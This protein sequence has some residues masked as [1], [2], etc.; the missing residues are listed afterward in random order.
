MALG[1]LLDSDINSQAAKN[2]GFRPPYAG[3]VG[4][5]AQS[6]RRFPHF[7]GITDPTE[8]LGLANYHSLQILVQ[9]RASYG[10]DLTLAYTLSKGISDAPLNANEG[11]A[12]V[13][14]VFNQRLDKTINSSDAPH[15]IAIGYSY[16]LPVGAGKAVSITHPVLNKVAGG[17]Q[18]TGMWRYYS[19]R[20]I[21]IGGAES[22][23]IFSGNRPQY[24]YPFVPIMTDIGPG[25]FDP[26]TDSY[27]NRAAF[28]TGQR[29]KFGDVP[30]RLPSTR[31]FAFYSENIGLL[32][33]IQIKE[34]VGVELRGEAYNFTNRTRFGGPN[35]TLTS[36]S[37]GRVTSSSSARQM[38]L[39]L[40]VS[41]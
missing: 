12:G 21:S 24:V 29:Y 35:T 8:N 40:R 13:M 19:G 16:A 18:I 4:S 22:T 32:K 6:L 31:G 33:K 14:D 41:F 27:L 39:G 5:V 26:A 17:W 34:R 1:T 7:T 23:G 30:A 10:L 3:F 9:K 38:Q 2:A 11:K 37:Y 20:P 25:E 36:V 28:T 15:N